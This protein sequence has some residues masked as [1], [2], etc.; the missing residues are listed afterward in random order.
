MR[1]DTALSLLGGTTATAAAWIGVVE[2]ATRRWIRGGIGDQSRDRV[3]AATLRKAAA[4]ALSIDVAE[5]W[6]DEM[7]YSRRL[8]NML[9]QHNAALVEFMRE[10][11]DKDPLDDAGELF[12][13]SGQDKPTALAA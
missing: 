5:W 13:K 10:K 7:V 6:T 2:E 3:L 8:E 1:T 11:L 12:N 4:D 9:L